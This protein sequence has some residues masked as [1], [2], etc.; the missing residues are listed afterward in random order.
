MSEVNFIIEVNEV[1]ELIKVEDVVR[2]I[3]EC[4]L[5]VSVEVK[6]NKWGR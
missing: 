3:V 6:I 2:K 5:S 4:F 1:K